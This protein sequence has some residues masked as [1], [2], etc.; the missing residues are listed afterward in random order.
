MVL[1]WE[2]PLDNF[3]R[4]ASKKFGT[5][6]DDGDEMRNHVQYEQYC[7][8]ESD[9][10][11][12]CDFYCCELECDVRGDVDSDVVDVIALLENRDEQWKIPHRK[13]VERLMELVGVTIDDLK[14]Y[15]ISCNDYHV[16][17]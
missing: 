4:M 16:P 12:K 5:A 13:N 6:K 1:D 8:E 7:L 10:E 3:N 14:W 15:L 17:A 2:V 9:V 11:R